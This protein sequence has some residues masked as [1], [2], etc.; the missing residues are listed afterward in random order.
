[1]RQYLIIDTTKKHRIN[2]LK[3]SL[4]EYDRYIRNKIIKG[5][6]YFIEILIDKDSKGKKNI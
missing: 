1:M 3:N 2:L 6:Q 4:A 5:F